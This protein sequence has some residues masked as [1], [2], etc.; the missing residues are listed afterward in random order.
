MAW[1][2]SPRP[3][4]LTTTQTSATS[5]ISP[6]GLSGPDGL[7][8]DHIATG[9]V[10]QIHDEVDASSETAEMTARGDRADEDAGVFRMPLHADA[11]AKHGPAGNRARRIDGGDGD[12]ASGRAQM[13]YVGV[14]ERRFARS[15]AAEADD[16]GPPGRRINRPGNRVGER[17]SLFGQRQASRKRGRLAAP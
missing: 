4:A 17:A 12:G 3:G 10:H 5:T 7:D 9:G 1:M 2:S 11:V 13:G 14:D 15:R 16:G 6:S 8:D